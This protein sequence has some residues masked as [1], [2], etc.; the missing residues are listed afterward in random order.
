M[1]DQ[2]LFSVITPT[3][4][5]PEK[6]EICVASVKAQLCINYEHIVIVDDAPD[7]TAMHIPIGVSKNIIILYTG[8]NTNNWGNTPKQIGITAAK[9]KYLVFLDDD[10]IIFP[11]YLQSFQ[12]H[13]EHN[14][15]DCLITCKILHCGPLYNRAVPAILDGFVLKTRYIDALQ[16]VV[17]SELA[18]RFGYVNDGYL[19]DGKSIEQWASA[20]FSIGHLTQILGIHL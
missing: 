3:Y 12:T 7:T 11:N 6:L 1:M 9:G 4:K 10:N 19:S 20:T 17:K 14:A 16:V 13:I 18:K 15:M 2:P 5:R 8:F